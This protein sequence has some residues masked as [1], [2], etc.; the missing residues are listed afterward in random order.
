MMTPA[1]IIKATIGI[2]PPSSNNYASCYAIPIS[3]PKPV[4]KKGHNGPHQS[5]YTFEKGITK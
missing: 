1:E 4:D 2:S 5:H 3:T